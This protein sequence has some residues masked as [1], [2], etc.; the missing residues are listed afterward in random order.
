MR[1]KGS[2]IAITGA[3]SGI[4]EATALAFAKKGARLE[5]CARRIERLNAVAEKC[6]KA[7]SPEVHVRVVD[8]GQ[9]GQARTFIATALRDFQRLDILVNNAG[10][11]NVSD[12]E[13]TSEELWD[14]VVNVNQKGVWLGMKESVAAMR[15]RG[16]GSIINIS[17]I[18]GLVGS[19]ASAAYHG[20]KGAVRLLTKVAAVRYAPEKIRVNSVHPGP[21][22]T[23]MLE[24]LP[25][26]NLKAMVEN[27]VPMKREGTPEEVANVVLFLASDEASYVTGA[28]FVVDGGF[29]AR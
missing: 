25:E 16:A 3:S 23:Q 20:T 9:T 4:G 2:V 11:Y 21:I 17:S 28:E 26:A 14:T 18:Y 7:G 13:E 5:L 24:G 8:V 10:I 27:D 29:T 6:R 15:R 12:I 1:L 22:H 19:P